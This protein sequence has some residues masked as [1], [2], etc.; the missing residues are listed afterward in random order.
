MH[1][2]SNICRRSQT[3]A[4]PHMHT[5]LLGLPNSLSLLFFLNSKHTSNFAITCATPGRTF[6]KSNSYN[7]S[8]RQSQS[9]ISTLQEQGVGLH[10]QNETL[11]SLCLLW[12]ISPK[13]AQGYQ[14]HP[15]QGTERESLRARHAAPPGG[16]LW[17]CVCVCVWCETHQGAKLKPGNLCRKSEALPQLVHN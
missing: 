14:T 13:N 7:Q 6:I 11:R 8:Y 2:L 9:Q 5:L 4:R 3:Y 12:P 16:G 10:T 15:Q 17:W 1:T